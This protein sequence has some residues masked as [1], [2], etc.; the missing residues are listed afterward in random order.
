VTSPLPPPLDQDAWDEAATEYAIE[1]LTRIRS[2][3][4]KWVGTISA[5][6]GIFGT[7][8]LVGGPAT[9]IDVGSRGQQQAVFFVLALAAGLAAAGI[10]LGGLAAQG[11]TRE[12]DN[13]N[14]ATFA[15]YIAHNGGVAARQLAASRWLGAAAAAFVLGG[16]LFGVWSS[17][18]GQSAL[19]VDHVVVVL[20]NGAVVCVDVAAPTGGVRTDG[21]KPRQPQHVA[22][23]RRC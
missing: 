14:G 3:A 7:V 18:S 23:V 15:A 12:W 9:M 5:L 13:W 20:R 19:S 8:F 11:R 17:M 21:S 2:A 22:P 16:G 1:S 4:E 10:I 6:M